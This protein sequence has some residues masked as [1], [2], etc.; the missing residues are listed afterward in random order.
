MPLG[1]A[2]AYGGAAVAGSYGVGTLTTG[3]ATAGAIGGT[4]GPEVTDPVLQS[5]VAELFQLSD[6]I[7]G[8]TA[9]AVRYEA[10]TGILLSDAGHFQ[11]AREILGHLNELI[12]TGG[13]SVHDQVVAKGLA[14]DLSQALL[15][16]R[17]WGAV[18]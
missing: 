17:S 9:G 15:V 2:V 1:G 12:R 13:L 8:G 6:K 11:E 16:A 3:V 14:Q 7:P 4:A 5:W 10:R 18:K